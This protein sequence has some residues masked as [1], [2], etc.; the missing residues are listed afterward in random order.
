MQLLLRPSQQ[1]STQPSASQV[2]NVSNKRLISL[3]SRWPISR[4]NGLEFLDLFDASKP[5]VEVPPEAASVSHTFYRKGDTNTPAPIAQP[6][7]LPPEPTSPTRSR[8]TTASA[9]VP[10]APAPAAGSSSITE[11]PLSSAGSSGMITI[12]IPS[13][14]D[15]DRRPVE[16]LADEIK[17]HSVPDEEKFELLT[18]IRSAAALGKGPAKQKEREN[19]VIIRLLAIAIFGE[20]FRR[21]SPLI[22][23]ASGIGKRI[24]AELAHPLLSSHSQ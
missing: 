2:N 11:Q 4:E 9:T 1:Y 5:D 13:L 10:T 20:L 17:K 6:V 7:F 21:S 14:L 15:S 23:Q 24:F 22:Y 16:I 18:R 8:G 3:A 12:Y 19:I